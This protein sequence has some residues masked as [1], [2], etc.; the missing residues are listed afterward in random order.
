M[1][2]KQYLKSRPVCKV[3]FQLP[4]IMDAETIK[5]AGDFNNWSATPMEQLKDGRFKTVVELEQGR[6]YQFRYLVN[7]QE[8]M[9]EEEADSYVS[10]PFN[11]ENSVL[12]V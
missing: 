12:S 1:I 6:D 7:D 9:N 10:T 11:S 5:L 2:K 8:W 4:S 3:T